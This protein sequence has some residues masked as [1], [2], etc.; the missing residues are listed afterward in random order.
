M[1][2]SSQQPVYKCLKIEDPSKTRFFEK[3]TFAGDKTL[4]W[5]LNSDD[6][7]IKTTHTH[8]I[9]AIEL[10]EG[11]LFVGYAD[12]ALHIWKNLRRKRSHV[13]KTISSASKKKSE[14]D[15]V[16]VLTKKFKELETKKLKD[17]SAIS[18][19]HF[20]GRTLFLGGKNAHIL[21]FEKD[22]VSMR[23]PEQYNFSADKSRIIYAELP[24]H[25]INSHKN[26]IFTG[27]DFYT[28][29]WSSE[30]DLCVKVLP[31]TQELPT[32]RDDNN[33][34]AMNKECKVTCLQVMYGMLIVGNSLGSID[35]WDLENFAFMRRIQA[36]KTCNGIASMELREHFLYVTTELGTDVLIY[37]LTSKEEPSWSCT[38]S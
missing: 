36:P 28:A 4:L 13:T 30:T 37:D 16:D 31:A 25:V 11:T 3:K 23:K 15:S 19:I 2:N 27:H 33:L 24:I 26:L 14:T 22:V 12:G 5:E 29:C 6:G 35:F 21:I 32:A 34:P 7:Y 9:T 1:T 8:D 20:N 10:K 17:G 18:A 38:I